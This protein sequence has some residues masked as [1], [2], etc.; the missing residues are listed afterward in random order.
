MKEIFISEN[1]DYAPNV[2]TSIVFDCNLEQWKVK[3]AFPLSGLGM[4]EGILF[5]RNVLHITNNLKTLKIFAKK[6][7]LSMTNSA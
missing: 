3:L 2:W 7:T 1:C 4:T 6:L 5:S